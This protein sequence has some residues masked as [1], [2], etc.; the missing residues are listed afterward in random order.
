MPDRHGRRPGRPA[1]GER[2]VLRGE[3]P[4]HD[5]VRP[6][7]GRGDEA[8]PGNGGRDRGRVAPPRH[9]PGRHQERHPG[10]QAGD[11]GV[12][13]QD[14]PVPLR[15]RGEDHRRGRLPVEGQ[16]DHHPPPRAVR[17]ERVSERPEGAGDPDRRADPG[18][19][20]R[21]HRDD[22]PPS[23]PQ[24][25]P[26][27]RR[28]RSRSSTRTSGPSSTPRWWSCSPPSWTGSS[29]SAGWGRSRGS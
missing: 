23:V 26:H 22:R 17:R 14:G 6:L 4:H 11:L 1:G 29:I 25:E 5:G 24:P 27:A 18:R 28:R 8:R 9:R 20:R 21:L 10:R 15:K 16:A 12:G 13:V 7:R 2:P 3:L 19:G